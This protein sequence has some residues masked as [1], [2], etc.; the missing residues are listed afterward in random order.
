MAFSQARSASILHVVNQIPE[1]TLIV[2]RI[3]TSV[4][5]LSGRKNFLAKFLEVVFTFTQEAHRLRHK[6][7]P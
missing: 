4:K 3:L 1:R 6:L 7:I 2:F 5:A